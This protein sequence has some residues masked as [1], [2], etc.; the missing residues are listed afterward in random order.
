MHHAGV[1]VF[2]GV[3]L[4]KCLSAAPCTPCVRCTRQYALDVF[5]DCV[6]ANEEDIVVMT[7]QRVLVLDRSR[8]TVKFQTKWADVDSVRAEPQ[9][10]VPT[11]AYVQITSRGVGR[12]DLLTDTSVARQLV[13]AMEKIRHESTFA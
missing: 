1:G 6:Q 13:D 9:R 4:A 8:L 12:H 3:R 2:D 5:Y 10:G 7:N 11:S